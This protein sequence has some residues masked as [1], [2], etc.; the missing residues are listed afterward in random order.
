VSARPA[1]QSLSL[2]GN[3]FIFSFNTIPG[4]SYV[5]EYKDALQQTQWQTLSTTPGDG[6]LK[7]ITN[8]TASPAQRFYR[9]NIQ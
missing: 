1:L 4:K 6:T 8:S 9:L 3:Q 5:L 2:N 7:T